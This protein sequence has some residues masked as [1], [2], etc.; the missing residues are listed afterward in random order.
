[1]FSLL[2][3][4]VVGGVYWFHLV[5][6]SVRPAFRVRSV[7]PT[8]L[9]GSISYLYILSSNFRRCVACIVYCKI[10]K[11]ELLAIF[12]N[13]QLWLFLVLTL[14]LIWIPS[15]G[16]HGAAGGISERRRS[17]CSSCR[18]VKVVEQTMELKVISEPMLLMW[19]K[20]NEARSSHRHQIWWSQ[21]I[22]LFSTAKSQLTFQFE[23][24]W[25][26]CLI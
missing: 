24:H 23:P 8:V 22:S 16:N 15:M 18:R 13:L 21:F 20:R 19:R 6:P 25:F 11:F 12:L 9:V 5:R 10:S 4:E 26:P 2:Y 17:S 7:A 3:N 14:D 1:M